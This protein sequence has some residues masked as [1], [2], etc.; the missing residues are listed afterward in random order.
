MTWAMPGGRGGVFMVF[1]GSIGVDRVS[2]SGS[3]GLTN[4]CTLLDEAGGNAKRLEVA[5]TNGNRQALTLAVNHDGIAVSA[6]GGNDLGDAGGSGGNVG[7][8]AN[9]ANVNG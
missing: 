8:R 3:A 6:V 7:A 2:V 1:D 4:N 5:I 9:S